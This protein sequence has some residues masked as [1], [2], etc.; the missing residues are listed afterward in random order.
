MLD[1][2][3]VIALVHAIRGIR[4]KDDCSPADIDEMDCLVSQLENG[5]SDPEMYN[6]L[7]GSLMTAEEIADK[8]LDYRPTQL[9]PP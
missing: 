8:A 9:P 2:D 7:F 5:V 4:N 6:Y 3:E 1:K